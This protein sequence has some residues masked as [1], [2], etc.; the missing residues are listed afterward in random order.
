MTLDMSYELSGVNVS[1]TSAPADLTYSSPVPASYLPMF[2]DNLWDLKVGYIETYDVAASM[3]GYAIASAPGYFSETENFS[4]YLVGTENW[5][6]IAKY[7]THRL[8]GRTYSKVVH[9]RR[10]GYT[11]VPNSQEIDRFEGDLWLAEGIGMIESNYISGVF[12]D[13]LKLKRSSEL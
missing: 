2:K 1:A 10:S 13:S 5:R 4:D 7:D 11:V 8:N 9:V 6:I 12:I 3:S